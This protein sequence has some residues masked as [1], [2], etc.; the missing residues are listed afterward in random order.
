MRTVS[1]QNSFQRK[2]EAAV[3]KIFNVSGDCKPN[4]HYMVDIS[5]RLRKIGEFVDK[6]EYFTINRAR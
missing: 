3:G 2:G 4:Q 6:G 1:V 5:E